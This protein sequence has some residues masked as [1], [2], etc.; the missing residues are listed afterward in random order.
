[1]PGQSWAA[2][3]SPR[4]SLQRVGV[5]LQG[6]AWVGDAHGSGSGC[7]ELFDQRPDRGTVVGFEVAPQ[8]QAPIAAPTTATPPPPDRVAARRGV[9]D[10]P[11]RDTRGSA[12]RSYAATSG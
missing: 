6:G 4:T 12:G 2:R 1:M 8:P 11:G 7:G 3:A 10:R 5:A 9:A